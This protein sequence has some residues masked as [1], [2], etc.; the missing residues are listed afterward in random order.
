MIGERTKLMELGATNPTGSEGIIYVRGVY[1]ESKVLEKKKI[2]TTPVLEKMKL[3]AQLARA[4]FVIFP[5]IFKIRLRCWR[6]KKISFIPPVIDYDILPFKIRDLT[7][8]V[9]GLWL[10][11]NIVNNFSNKSQEGQKVTTENGKEIEREKVEGSADLIGEFLQKMRSIDLNK[12]MDEIRDKIDKNR[13]LTAIDIA[14]HFEV[15]GWGDVLWSLINL[16]ITGKV[17]TYDGFDITVKYPWLGEERINSKHIDQ[18]IE[19][20]LEGNIRWVWS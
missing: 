3:R 11:G 4:E 2:D 9:W 1:L 14:S 17:K 7:L 5:C 6:E 13:P 15:K 16:L 18:T 19:L 12:S 8:H 20:P 10:E